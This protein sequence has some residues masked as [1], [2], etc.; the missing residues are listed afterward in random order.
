MQGVD[1]APLLSMLGTGTVTAPTHSWINDRHA[2]AADNAVLELSDFVGGITPTKASSSNNAQIII[3]EVDVTDRE[4]Q[5]SQYGMKEWPYQVGKQ[6]VKH[7]KDVEFAIL[8]LGNTT[9]F[10][11]PTD[12]TAVVEPRMAGLFHYVSA[13]NHQDLDSS[14]DGLGADTAMTYDKLHT[15]LEPLY[16]NGAMEDDT[17]HM[18]LGTKIKQTINKFADNYLQKNNGEGKFDPTLWTLTTDFGDIKLRLH[19]LFNTPALTN[20]VLVGQFGRARTLYVPNRKG[21]FEDVPTSKT[22]KFARYTSDLTLEVKNGDFFASASG[23]F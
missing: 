20:K 12:G 5:M 11:A 15:I 17:F 2:D 6:G 18:L 23:L 8:G 22:A 10:D 3:T 14:G 1:K 4:I 16:N 19:R 21:A 9:V 7:T 13:G